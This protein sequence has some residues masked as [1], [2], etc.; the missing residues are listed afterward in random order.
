MKVIILV[1]LITVFTLAT[2][3]P[4]IEPVV[5]HIPRTYKVSLDDSP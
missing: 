3:V 2:V 5:S 1:G 4:R